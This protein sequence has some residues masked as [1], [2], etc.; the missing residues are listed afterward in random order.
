M[1]MSEYTNIHFDEIEK[2]QYVLLIA[3]KRQAVVILY[4]SR[5]RII[6]RRLQGL[7]WCMV[8]FPATKTHNFI[9]YLVQRCKNQRD[10][11]FVL[12]TLSYALFS[13]YSTLSPTALQ[14]SPVGGRWC[15]MYLCTVEV[16][17]NICPTNPWPDKGRNLRNPGDQPGTICIWVL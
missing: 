13:L 7:I 9:N 17:H 3:Q 12:E 8:D 4:T 6:R 16:V 5:F 2:P 14:R 15:I 10:L 11:A 1:F